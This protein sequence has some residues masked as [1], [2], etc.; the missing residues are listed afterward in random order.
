MKKIIPALLLLS[1]VFAACSS[2]EK[3]V[4]KKQKTNTSKPKK[5]WNKPKRKTQNVF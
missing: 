2:D 3:T 4:R 1:F 5:P